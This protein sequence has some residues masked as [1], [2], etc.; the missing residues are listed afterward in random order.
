MAENQVAARLAK[1]VEMLATGTDS[2]QER[3]SA[4]WLELM[5]LTRHDFPEALQQYFGVV[6]SEILAAPDDP[7]TVGT[8]DA[9][10]SADR[11][12]RLAL[13]VWTSPEQN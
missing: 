3:V 7:A 8:D 13:L 9:A 11:I 12:F 4:A 1:A 6:E 2:I 5:P 10:A